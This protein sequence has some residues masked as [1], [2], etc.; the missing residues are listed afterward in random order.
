GRDARPRR[1]LRAAHLPPELGTSLLSCPSRPRGAARRRSAAV[2]ARILHRADGS[3]AEPLIRAF[4]YKPYRNYR[5]YPRKAQDAV[6][7]A[8][9]QS[10]LDHPDGIVV[11]ADGG[12]AQAAAIGRRLEW[13]S[14][15]FNVSMGRIDYL[16]G[17]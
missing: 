11:V 14:Q 4:P 8:E 17:S 13:D 6:M 7:L 2:K 5:V 9:V 10:T 3:I 12:D 1:R 16:L 15:F